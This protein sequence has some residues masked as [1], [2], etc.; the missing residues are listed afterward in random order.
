[1]TFKVI[2]GQGQGEEMTSVPIGTIL[3]DYDYVTDYYCWWYYFSYCSLIVITVVAMV[4]FYVYDCSKRKLIWI[5][6]GM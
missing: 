5:K 4:G 2:R 1:M 3:C 6:F